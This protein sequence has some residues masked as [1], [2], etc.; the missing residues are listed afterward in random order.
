MRYLVHHTQASEIPGRIEYLYDIFH[1]YFLPRNMEGSYI[2]LVP[3]GHLELS[4]L[5]ITGHSD[6]VMQYLEQYIEQIPERIVIATTC[7][8]RHLEKYKQ[9]KQIYVPKSHD[10]YC[11]VFDGIP[12]GFSFEISYPELDF[13]NAS[14]DFISKLQSSYHKL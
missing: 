11:Y 12:Y 3:I 10:E 6:C 4:V 9:T 5:F 8:A 2:P 7:F 1:V 14:G 13:Y